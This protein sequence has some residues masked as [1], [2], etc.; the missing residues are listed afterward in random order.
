MTGARCYIAA[1]GIVFALLF[2]AH[3]AR[4]FAEG[5]EILRQPTIIVTSIAS[6]GLAIW[7][8]ILLTRKPGA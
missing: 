3:V 7:A 1:T 4:V 6:L 8:I 2:I 5:T